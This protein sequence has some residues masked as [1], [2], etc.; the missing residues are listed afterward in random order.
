M[1][2][3][4]TQL[5]SISLVAR[6]GTLG[7]AA[8][9][10]GVSQPALSR[11]ITEAEKSL[12]LALFERAPRGVKPTEACRA[13]L[14][15][16]EAALACIDEGREAA[17][18][19]ERKR[20]REVSLALLESLCDE[21]LVS[22][23]QAMLTELS[24]QCV[25]LI[26]VRSSSEVSDEV[27][28]GRV[29]LGLSYR[30]DN[31]T[32]VESVWIADDPIV[33]VCSPSHPLA[34][35]GEKLTTERLES[36]KW[37]GSPEDTVNTTVQETNKVRSRRDAI[38]A[39]TVYAR[40]NLINSGY[41]VGMM[42]RVHIESQLKSGDLVELDTPYSV[43]LPIYLTWRRGGNLGVAGEYLRDQLVRAYR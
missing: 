16:A 33:A 34:K 27:I 38:S 23:H 12:G 43:E 5:K 40:T 28:S 6:L 10:L 18:D 30:R 32:Q 22:A 26:N 37:V 39:F 41:C 1:S 42:R 3:G 9:A 15:H 4:L 29:K 8:E 24:V 17:Q 11:R 14:R 20:I 25:N 13:F 7:R 31:S 19:V 21:R 35:A 36:V 2:L